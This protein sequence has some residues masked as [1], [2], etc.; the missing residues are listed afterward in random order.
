MFPMDNERAYKDTYCTGY[1]NRYTFEFDFLPNILPPLYKKEEIND[2]GMTH[3]SEWKKVLLKKGVRSDF[4]IDKMSVEK[5]ELDNGNIQF[6]YT[7]PK[8]EYTPEC[9]FAILHF[10]KNKDWKYYTLELDYLNILLKKSGGIIC[11][12]KDDVHLNYGAHCKGDLEEFQKCVQNI[13]DGKPNHIFAS[14][15]GEKERE[16]VNLTPE[17]LKEECFIF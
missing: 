10:D 13:I 2:Y 15:D 17:K 6:V 14:F 7:F 11:G 4:G 16:V 8:P 5:K 9:Y 3:P 12:Q 1:I